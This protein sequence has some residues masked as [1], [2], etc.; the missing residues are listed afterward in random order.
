M[1]SRL[2][3]VVILFVAFSSCAL[4]QSAKPKASLLQ[5]SL[6]ETFS[7][8]LEQ[9]EKDGFELKDYFYPYQDGL[10]PHLVTLLEKEVDLVGRVSEFRIYRSDAQGTELLRRDVFERRALSFHELNNSDV[11]GDGLR[12]IVIW[13]GCSG[14]AWS[15]QQVRV[16]QVQGS[17][18]IH[19]TEPISGSLFPKSLVDLDQDGSL[20]VIAVETRW[21]SYEYLP[22]VIAPSVEEIFAWRNG[23]YQRANSDYPDFYQS[24]ISELE[25]AIDQTENPYEYLGNAVR[26]LLNYVRMGQ[27]TQGW[28]E[29]ERLLQT[30]RASIVETEVWQ[31][32]KDPIWEDFK[33]VI[34]N[35]PEG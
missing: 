17:R 19:L 15:C 26:L 12:E 27:P 16:Y 7:E 22:H 11:N 3:W 32:I 9:L 20:E 21:E 13:K 29:F 34:D 33:A 10:A 30:E 24:R 2:Y 28:E 35:E 18:S 8:E 14:T 25:S 5:E 1:Q 6:P 4:L 31:S 23:S